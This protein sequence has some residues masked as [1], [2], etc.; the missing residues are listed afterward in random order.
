MM[1]SKFTLKGLMLVAAMMLGGASSAWAASVDLTSRTTPNNE[2]YYVSFQSGSNQLYGPTERAR[3]WDCY[4]QDANGVKVDKSSR[5]VECTIG[6]G[7]DALLKKEVLL[8]FS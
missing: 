7:D 8:Q 3:A 6:T 1:K 2:L 4:T 5:Y